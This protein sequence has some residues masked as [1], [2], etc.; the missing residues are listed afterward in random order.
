[1]KLTSDEAYEILKKAKEDGKIKEFRI[2]LEL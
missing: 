1:M 2:Q